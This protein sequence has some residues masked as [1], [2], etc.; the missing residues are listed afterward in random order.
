VQ[1]LVLYQTLVELVDARLLIEMA[2]NVHIVNKIWPNGQVDPLL[3]GLAQPDQKVHNIIVDSLV[4]T[5]QQVLLLQLAEYLSLLIDLLGQ[6]DSIFVVVDAQTQEE[7]HNIIAVLKVS[8]H[9]F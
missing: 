4:R 3:D 8:L 9:D 1:V 2:E 6:L 5:V 7:L